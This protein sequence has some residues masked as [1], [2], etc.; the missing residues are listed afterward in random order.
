MKQELRL[1]IAVKLLGWAFSILPRGHK[2]TQS[3]AIYLKNH[4]HD[5][6]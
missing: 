1:L 3:L 4:I 6:E 2:A 5:Y